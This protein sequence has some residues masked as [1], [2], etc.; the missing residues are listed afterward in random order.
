MFLHSDIHA[1]GGATLMVQHLGSG[2][3]VLRRLGSAGGYDLVMVVD[4]DREGA[5][6][7]FAWMKTTDDA[8]GAVDLVAGTFT[9]LDRL[10]A[11][12][13]RQADKFCGL[14]IAAVGTGAVEPGRFVGEGLDNSDVTRL[15][16]Q[17]KYS[18]VEAR[19]CAQKYVH[20]TDV[21][22][23]VETALML[24]EATALRGGD[25][26]YL[27]VLQEKFV[28]VATAATDW[29]EQQPNV[30]AE[31]VDREA[32]GLVATVFTSLPDGQYLV[33]LLNDGQ[34]LYETVTLQVS[35][36]TYVVTESADSNLFVNML[37]GAYMCG[38]TLIFACLTNR[39]G[40]RPELFG[41]RLGNGTLLGLTADQ[42]QELY[43]ASGGVDE[44]TYTDAPG[45]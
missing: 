41:Y 14:Q 23:D 15:V 5:V 35:E 4:E 37:A 24:V 3:V 19:V 16:A 42:M 12:H 8:Q 45:R 25:S 11:K 26:A 40:H 21:L 2:E 18:A 10:C 33:T 7:P 17:L 43:V 28:S 29:L 38:G 36:G 22:T 39:E 32:V 44:V 27:S 6:G 1:E 20:D 13:P 9:D 34:K 30:D 31:T